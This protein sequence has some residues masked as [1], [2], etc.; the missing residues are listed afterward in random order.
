MVWAASVA[1][2]R[3]PFCGMERST[4]RFL[5]DEDRVAV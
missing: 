4:Q 2:F 1:A 5:K 3:S